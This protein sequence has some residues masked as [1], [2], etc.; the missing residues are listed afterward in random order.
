MN[1]WTGAAVRRKAARRAITTIQGFPNLK[2]IALA[3]LRLYYPA[4]WTRRKGY[5]SLISK[6][7]PLNLLETLFSGPRS[8]PAG[9][10]YFF[11]LEA[12]EDLAGPPQHLPRQ[13]CQASDFNSIALVGCSGND[14]PQEHDVIS[15]FLDCHTV[16]LNSGMDSGHLGKLVIMSCEKGL[17]LVLLVLNQILGDRPGNGQPIECSGAAANFVQQNQAAVGGGIE[18][19]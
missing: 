15:G 17:C 1:T 5:R 11:S 16:I 4:D 7:R 19:V 13:T 2:V 6:E 12:L 8:G 18:Y 3:S 9:K 14:P 10:I